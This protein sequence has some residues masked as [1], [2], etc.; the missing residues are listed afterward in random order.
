MT[1]G[2]GNV[3]C[4]GSGGFLACSGS[5]KILIK[6]EQFRSIFVHFWCEQLL[7]LDIKRCEK[8]AI[9]YSFFFYKF[10]FS[11]VEKLYFISFFVEKKYHF[12]FFTFF[13]NKCINRTSFK[14]V[15]LIFAYSD[16]KQRK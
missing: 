14:N 5:A 13:S 1:A 11:H 4:S 6:A 15:E 3:P 10:C 8:R 12:D 9:L 7:Q 2:R 16:S